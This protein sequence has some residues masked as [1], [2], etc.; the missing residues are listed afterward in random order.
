MKATWDREAEIRE[1]K[2]ARN[3]LMYLAPMMSVTPKA[4]FDEKYPIPPAI[5]APK[6]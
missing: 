1:I 6:N 4:D 3:E 5:P 2:R